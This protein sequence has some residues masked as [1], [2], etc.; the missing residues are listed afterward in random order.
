M[1]LETVIRTL[2]G[3]SRAEG[4]PCMD[5]NTFSRILGMDLVPDS[6]RIRRNYRSRPTK[7]MTDSSW[8]RWDA[9]TSTPWARQPGRTTLDYCSTS[10]TTCAPTNAPSRSGNGIQSG[11]RPPLPA[12][13]ETWVTGSHKALC[14]WAGPQRTR[15]WLVN[16]TAQ[17]TR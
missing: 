7:R 12:T 14:S 13:M 8:K 16:S 3:E 9:T 2:A 4:V 6:T 10:M 15:L 5:Q 1:T 17:S 11:R